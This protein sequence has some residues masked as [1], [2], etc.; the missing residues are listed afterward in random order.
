MLSNAYFLAKFRFD[1]AEN[2]PSKNLQNFVKFVNFADPNP[3]IYFPSKVRAVRRWSPNARASWRFQAFRGGA[4]RR[5]VGATVRRDRQQHRAQH[6]ARRLELGC[7]TNYKEN[8][9]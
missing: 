5:R 1:T 6:A 2:E 9:L 7:S 3:N 8:P 4:G